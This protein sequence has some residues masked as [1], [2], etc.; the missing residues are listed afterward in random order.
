MKRKQLLKSKRSD[1]SKEE[2]GQI[3]YSSSS[4][5]NSLDDILPTRTTTTDASS[6]IPSATDKI[7]TRAIMKPQIQNICG[8]CHSTCLTCT[9]SHAESDCLTCQEGLTFIA[10]KATTSSLSSA[11]NSSSTNNNTTTITTTT[12]FCVSPVAQLASQT[13]IHK[14]NAN[15]FWVAIG[16]LAGLAC[17][18]GLIFFVVRGPR[19]MRDTY[20]YDRVNET[21]LLA[22]YDDDVLDDAFLTYKQLKSKFKDE[23][24]DGEED[25]EEDVY[26]RTVDVVAQVV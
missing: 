19:N 22:E 25:E 23:P 14:L 4:Q 11:T 3:A 24:S 21:G 15:L 16:I 5:F 9:T 6:S 7:K 18:V 20:A 17:I 13:V 8:D 2:E 26:D 1:A 10:N 12:G